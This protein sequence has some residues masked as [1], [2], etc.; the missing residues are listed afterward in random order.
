MCTLSLFQNLKITSEAKTADEV[1]NP[2]AYVTNCISWPI[3]IRGSNGLFGVYSSRL[4]L[5]FYV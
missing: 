4:F 1:R 2:F 3:V 5:F